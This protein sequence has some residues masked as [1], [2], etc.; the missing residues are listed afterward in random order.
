[1]EGILHRGWNVRQSP[2]VY[3]K[4]NEERARSLAKHVPPILLGWTGGV[5]FKAAGRWPRPFF[6]RLSGPC[7]LSYPGSDLITSLEYLIYV[8]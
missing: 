8:P 4:T 2:S 5:F 6:I 7:R 1:M 3:R